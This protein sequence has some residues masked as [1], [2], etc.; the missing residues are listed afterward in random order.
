MFRITTR[1]LSGFLFGLMLAG[2]AAAQERPLLEI[3][4]FVFRGAF[5][6]PAGDFGVSS[7]NYS[8]GPLALCRGGSSFFI[9]GHSHHQALAEFPLPALVDSF[10]LD[11]LLMAEEPLQAF[12]SVLDHAS[13]GNPDNIDRIGG[14]WC[15]E[16]GEGPKL[17]VNGYEYY[18]ADANVTDS[19]LRVENPLDLSGSTVSGFFEFEDPAGHLSGWISEIPPEWQ[20]ALGGSHITGHSSGIPINGRASIGPS[21]FAFELDDLLGVTDPTT[22]IASEALLDFALAD[23]L[24]DDLSNA[25]RSNHLW[26][27]LSRAVYGFI[28]PGTRTYVT[29]GHSGGHASGVCYKCE[30]S[31]GVECGGY[32]APDINDYSLYY[33]LWD[34]EELVAA[35]EGRVLPSALRPYDYGPFP[36]AFETHE[37]GGGS[38][39]PSSGLL[40]LTLQRADTEQGEYATPPVVVAYRIVGAHTDA[41]F[42]DDFESGNVDVW[43]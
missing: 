38:W 3:D 41:I 34:V 39:D 25:S 21:A 32:C 23:P 30:Q 43:G 28:P 7:L 37:M 10:A 33:W 2:T 27:H 36:A 11:D 22:P 4:D 20:T 26:T 15:E 13:G 8:E 35:R 1:P 24:H 19:T 16:T 40:Y 9:V 29:L 18:D 6:V 31:N 14:L 42:S 12:A 17:L 5:R